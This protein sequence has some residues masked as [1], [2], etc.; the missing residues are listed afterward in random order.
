MEAAHCHVNRYR[1]TT[2]RLRGALRAVEV[3]VQGNLAL[4]YQYPAW[5][6][7]PPRLRPTLWNRKTSEM[8]RGAALK[9]SHLSPSRFL[10]CGFCTSAAAQT[11]RCSPGEFADARRLPQGLPIRPRGLQ[12]L[13]AVDHLPTHP[14]RQRAHFRIV[15]SSNPCLT[16]QGKLRGFSSPS[17]LHH[18]G[19]ARSGRRN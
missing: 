2:K 12:L 7:A 5:F 11:Y 3:L 1:L 6:G 18:W 9:Y 16:A 8:R 19:Q 17:P 14:T 10:G 15:L 4:M 13:S